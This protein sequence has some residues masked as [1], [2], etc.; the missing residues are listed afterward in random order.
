MK[1][2]TK[3]QKIIAIILLIIISTIYYFYN[4]NTQNNINEITD[5]N[6]SNNTNE[7]KNEIKEETKEIVTKKSVVHITGAVKN[8]GVYE[9]EPESRII[10]VINKAGGLAEDAD[11][12]TIN[13]A[14]KIEDGMKI[15]IPKKGENLENN[16]IENSNTITTESG[17][18]KTNTENENDKSNNQIKKVNINT[19]TK[20][21]L[22]TLPGIGES[23]AQKII[24]YR[25]KN[26]KF[27][28]IEEI[29]E[30]S[31]IGESK[32]EKIKDMIFV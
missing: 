9:L 15:H 13:L 29:K 28:N 16:T 14:Y 23:T 10:D 20:E 18:P 11:V 12:T 5:L 19:A 7:N 32:Y 30:V 26:G 24:D 4:K 25:N 6:L 8:S 22:D 17:L 1:E 21:E 31:G 2:I 3:K 27:T